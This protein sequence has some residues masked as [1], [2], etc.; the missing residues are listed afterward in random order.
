MKTWLRRAVVC[1]VVLLALAAAAQTQRNAVAFTV[2]MP[3][4]G[5]H[6]Y[7]IVAHCPE[8]QGET[9]EFRMP[10]WTPGY[11]GV[12]DY[13]A[14]V[15]NFSATDDA[16]RP[17]R[18]EKSAPNA[19]KVHHGRARAIKLNYDVLADNP[20]VAAAWLDETHGYITPGALFFY[21][22]GQLRRPAT[23]TIA[24]YAKWSVATGLD[25][26][27]PTK[28]HTYLASDF[29]VLY[30]S[31]ILMGN[32]ESLPP[33]TINGVPHD[34]LAYKLGRFDRQQFMTDLKAV[35]EAGTQIIGD[36]PY[37]HYTFLGMGPGMGGIEH[38][39]STAVPFTTYGESRESRK[40]T[41][42]FLAHEYF[43]NYNV[44]R[45]RPVAL[46]PFDYDKPNLTNMLWVSEGFTVYY[47]Y[48]ML[49]RSGRMTQEELLK[50][51]GGNI[52][53]YENSTG[54]LFQS[55]TESSWDSWNQGPFGGKPQN[56]IMRTISY[57][58]KGPVLGMLLDFK[59]RHETGNRKSLDD[60]MR[61]LYRKYYKELGRGWTDLEFRQTCENI[62]G[63]R[64]DENFDYASTTKAID[65]NKYL[66][67][68]GLKMDDAAVLPEAYLGALTEEVDDHLRIAAVV[69]G[70]AA[71]KAGLRAQDIIRSVDG[72][73]A[74]IKGL[75]V[76]VAARKP[77]DRMKLAIT[78]N[79]QES[80]VEVVLGN[81][82][83]Q[84]YHIAP[85]ANPDALQKQILDD[86]TR[87]TVH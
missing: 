5:T 47:E 61:E 83:R 16:G 13:A 73:S 75:L 58:D 72:A 66:A 53:S 54:H 80:E 36:I 69:P 23:I 85:I 26:V 82:L 41:L 71:D 3:N 17:L 62:A 45:I 50:S 22:P 78:R 48:L 1:Q 56:G 39:N 35:V 74:N 81:K 25:P 64:L 18:W 8:L 12:F 77:Q 33:F 32:L 70:S 7:H 68:A 63:V 20:F 57:Y 21:V 15:R 49:A 40:R 38:L 86:W 42:S 60:V 27:S 4:P 2:S 34:F 43:H 87:I 79:G 37:K 29:D 6:I 51:L 31:P 19:W 52:A 67:Y 9:V 24:P 76:A 84:S 44:K 65:Y 30:D 59:I 10:V 55:A 14:K 46:G 11:Y 28:P